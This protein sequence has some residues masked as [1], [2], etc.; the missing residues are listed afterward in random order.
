MLNMN[1]VGSEGFKQGRKDAEVFYEI[2][3]EVG[4][5]EEPTQNKVELFIDGISTLSINGVAEFVRDGLDPP[6]EAYKPA[7]PLE[8]REYLT[9]VQTTPSIFIKDV[10]CVDEEFVRQLRLGENSIE[11][12]R[13]LLEFSDPKDGVLSVLEFPEIDR[14][15]RELEL[16]ATKK[17]ITLIT[18]QLHNISFYIDTNDINAW[19][20]LKQTAEDICQEAFRDYSEHLRK[21]R[22]SGEE[23]TSIRD[24]ANTMEDLLARRDRAINLAQGNMTASVWERNRLMETLP[25]RMRSQLENYFAEIQ[26][27]EPD[28]LRDPDIDNTNP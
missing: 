1:E 9:W 25:P 15:L 3:R 14:K 21:R 24:V 13:L 6:I 22:E 10:G 4:A 16:E 26:E 12:L 20:R 23:K 27:L 8:V 17:V 19:K 11:Q 28:E 2:I 5:G 7:D 18:L